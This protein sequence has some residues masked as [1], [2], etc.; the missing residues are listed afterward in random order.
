MGGGG[1]IFKE[2]KIVT[3]NNIIIVPQTHRLRSDGE[4]AEKIIKRKR[5]S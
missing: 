4:K 2:I 5:G 3:E 1:T